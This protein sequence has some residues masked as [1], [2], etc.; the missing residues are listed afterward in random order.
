MTDFVAN[1]GNCTLVSKEGEKREVPMEVA[2]MSVLVKEMTD[3]DNGDET[4]PEIPL[5]N[6]AIKVLDKVIEFCKHHVKEPMQEIEKPLKSPNMNE[7]VSEWDARFVDIDQETLF[8]LILAANYLDIKPLLDL[9]CAKVAS[10]IK[11][12]SPEEIR[13][14]FNIT[15][16]FTPEEEARVRDE[17]KWCEETNSQ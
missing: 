4:N 1:K 2:Q 8:E 9:T 16:D 3:E 11:N 15:N 10:M 17:N 12:K 13:E 7:V 14:T 5:P 6:V